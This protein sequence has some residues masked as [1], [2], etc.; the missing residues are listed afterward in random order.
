[1]SLLIF[2]KKVDD[3]ILVPNNSALMVRN[4][5]QIGAWTN[6]TQ[7]PYGSEAKIAVLDYQ[8]KYGTLGQT[9]TKWGLIWFVCEEGCLPKNVVLGTYIKTR[10]LASFEETIITVIAEGYEPAMGLLTPAFVKH[11]G[12]KDGMPTSYFSL[13][14]TWEPRPQ[15]AETDR[16]IELLSQAADHTFVDNNTNLIDLSE[17]SPQEVR[18][19]MSTSCPTELPGFDD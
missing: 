3:G 7:K 4:N 18:Q 1:M 13:A 12:V 15:G 9:T 2:G 16:R 8:Q 14:W 10:S 6:S 5:C 17:L 19:L 11:S